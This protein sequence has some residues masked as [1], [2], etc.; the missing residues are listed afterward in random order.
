MKK[1]NTSKQKMPRRDFLAA[2]AVATTAV[3]PATVK[4]KQADGKLVVGV[5]GMQRGR[6]LVD[7]F[8]KHADVVVK[9]VCDVDSQRPVSSNRTIA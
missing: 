8:A 1:T 5:M 7:T 3:V 6:S 2:S 9:Y 4:A